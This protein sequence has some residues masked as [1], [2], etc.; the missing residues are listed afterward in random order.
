MS[1]HLFASTASGQRIPG[2]LFFEDFDDDPDVANPAPAM[3]APPPQPDPPAITQA[4]L[5]AARAAG[6]ASGLHAARAEAVT[7]HRATIAAGVASIAAALRDADAQGARHA[8]AAAQAT[9]RLLLAALAALFPALCARHAAGE[10]AAVAAAVLPALDA[11]ECVTLQVHPAT[12]TAVSAALATLDP[13][14]RARLAP[15][16]DDA[17]LPGDARIAW[18]DGAASRDTASLWAAVA[19][20]LGPLDLLPGTPL[21]ETTERDG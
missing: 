2:V 13:G 7:R 9:A 18:L 14:L 19:A 11:Q 21:P 1:G 12:M 20:A 4:D 5:D 6:H 16:A 10:I 15:V 3:A 8:E 17:L